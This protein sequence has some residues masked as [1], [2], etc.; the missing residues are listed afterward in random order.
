MKVPAAKPKTALD[1]MPTN[2]TPV[3]AFLACQTQ[4]RV[5]A[6]MGGLVFLGVD[7]AEARSALADLDAP[8]SK[9]ADLRVM[10]AA[11]LPI[12]NEAR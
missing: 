2:W 12:L 1:I 11:A 3:A 6:T 10:E 8:A 9:I 4:W 5:V 7:Y